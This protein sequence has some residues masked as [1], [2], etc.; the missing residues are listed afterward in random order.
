MVR[1]LEWAIA[2]SL[3]VLLLAPICLLVG[4]SVRSPAFRHGL[5]ILL[6]IKLLTPPLLAVELPLEAVSLLSWS[7]PGQTASVTAVVST[8]GV[9]LSTGQLTSLDHAEAGAID[10]TQLPSAVNPLEPISANAATAASVVAAGKTGLSAQA[11]LDPTCNSTEFAAAMF[12]WKDWPWQTCG[13]IAVSVWICG[14]VVMFGIQLSRMWNFWM[15]VRRG[16]FSSLELEN[17]L[18]RLV[19][20]LNRRSAPKAVL[21]DGVVSPMLLGFGPW[22]QIL[23]PEQLYRQLSS[24]A[25]ST[26]LLHELAHYYRG[27]HYVRLLELVASWLFWWHPAVWWAIRE[28]EVAEEECCDRWV[29]DRTASS[30]RCYAEALLDTI[31]FL[32][33]RNPLMPPVVS[34]LGNPRELRGRLVQIMQGHRQPVRLVLVRTAIALLACTLPVQPQLFAAAGESMSAMIIHALPAFSLGSVSAIEPLTARAEQNT[35]HPVTSTAESG[36]LSDAPAVVRDRLSHPPAQ[37]RPAA[38]IAKPDIAPAETASASSSATGENRPTAQAV[39]TPVSPGREWAVARSSNGQYRLIAST[40]RQVRLWNLTP[41]RITPV[42][43]QP[44]GARPPGYLPAVE[45][46]GPEPASMVDLSRYSIA[47]VAFLPG[48]SRFVTGGYDRQLRLWDARSGRLVRNFDEPTDA[49]L[50]VVADAGTYIAAGA[51]DGSLTVY[52]LASTS[53]LHR[54]QFNAPVNGV[55]FSPDGKFL[56]AV[57]GSWRTE[58][59][60]ELIVLNV[61]DWQIV[62]RYI[63]PRPAGALEFLHGS[64]EVTLGEW[65]GT[66][67]AIRLSDGA[68]LGQMRIA[69]ELISAAAFSSQAASWPRTRLPESEEPQAEL[70]PETEPDRTVPDFSD[71]VFIGPRVPTPRPMDRSTT[72]PGTS[73]LSPSNLR[74]PL[75]SLS[76]PQTASRNTNPNAAPPLVRQP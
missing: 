58:A 18:A 73:Q 10:L 57:L 65:D 1:L 63:T 68:R 50:S 21:V 72:R 32:C 20:Q 34:G 46:S 40:G 14:A 48:Q 5:W 62:H 38:A 64:E 47:T 8:A 35:E 15:R 23:F 42:D 53:M 16:S 28:I 9:D 41:D 25:R 11:C 75:R 3:L 13:L 2:N 67:H 60:G 4:R 54:I 44:P 74:L 76:T 31:D 24:E 27:D 33:E 51:R 36:V 55:R 61:G 70:P 43:S 19:R 17:E 22:A 6:L 26:L 49:V 71:A 37:M 7:G 69:K 56:V 29:V 52:D 39:P 45:R 30:P 66:L 12:G 59:T